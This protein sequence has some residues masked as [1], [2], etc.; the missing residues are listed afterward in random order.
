MGGA[1]PSAESGTAAASS[2][3]PAP[4]PAPA[5]VPAPAALPKQVSE[6]PP[7][8]QLRRPGLLVFPADESPGSR[9]GF[10]G[11]SAVNP[12]TG[13]LEP[14]RGPLPAMPKASEPSHHQ[15]P[16]RMDS[17][18]SV[19]STTTTVA[20]VTM[21]EELD[22][23]YNA[24]EVGGDTVPRRSMSSVVHAASFDDTTVVGRVVQ[25]GCVIFRS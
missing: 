24:A 23:L 3:T 20:D 18:R 22:R 17:I 9:D 25:A 1:T 10:A 14:V 21:D 7:P 8:Q 12:E 5:P 13:L 6:T 11:L 15:P 4:T 19:G 2:P 16:A